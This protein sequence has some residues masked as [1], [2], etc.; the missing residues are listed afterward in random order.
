MAD[1]KYG[2]AITVLEPA[3]KTSP[4][5]Q[6]LKLMLAYAYLKNNQED[7][8]LAIIQ[9]TV[10]DTSDAAVLNDV[11][12][13]MADAN[14]E[15]ETA[16]KYSE[17]SIR[18][19]GALVLKGSIDDLS[20][21]QFSLREAMYWDTLGWIYFRM[22]Q[23]EKAIS[24]LRPAWLLAE[25]SVIGDH[26]AQAYQKVG[27][28]SEAR[29]TYELALAVVGG[30]GNRDEILGHYKQLTGRMSPELYSTHRLPN[31]TWTMTPAEELGRMRTVKVA[32]QSAPSGSATFGIAFEPGKVE[33][34][35]Y[36]EG[37]IELK[38]FAA[39]V[40]T[41][42]FDVP[43]PDDGIPTRVVRRGILSCHSGECSFTLLPQNASFVPQTPHF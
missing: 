38:P 19:T 18:A 23:F 17:D 16:K 25:D 13:E 14:V 24:Y 5:S 12:Y 36:M 28:N 30:N 40:K 31:G 35:V 9:K 15:L 21:L 43:F 20:S 26:L 6:N 42:K 3:V 2:D 32:V 33:D 1:K 29:H 11:A 4:D 41:A 27:K 37:A 7:K 34:V 10:N 39:K 22:G 8:G